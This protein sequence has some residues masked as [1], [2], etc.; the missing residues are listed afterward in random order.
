MD[1]KQLRYFVTVVKMRSFSAAGKS[2]FISQSTLSKSMQNLE[3]E[4]GV[5]LIYFNA[6]KL[7]TTSY[8]T[9][10]YNLAQN[11]LSQYE[12]IS[13]SL[14]GMAALEKGSL[15]IGIP[16][17]IGTCVF[18]RL[19]TGFIQ[20]YP[21]IDLI[22]TQDKA[23]VIQ[24]M[25][26]SNRLDFGFTMLPVTNEFLSIPLIRER[27]VCVV[28]KS[29]PLAEK[30]LIHFSDLKNEKLILLDEKFRMYTNVLTYCRRE[31]FE[32]HIIMQLQEWDLILQLVKYNVG[33]TILPKPI[34]ELYPDEDLVSV[35]LNV[36]TADFSIAMISPKNQYETN[37]MRVFKEHI[38]AAAALQNPALFPEEEEN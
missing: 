18:P 31:N 17:I 2:L 9:E 14:H 5:P 16:P 26:A 32:P 15:R 8:G 38:Q 34:V 7:H 28:H 25:V 11:L 21:G 30:E 29:N 12:A 19:I 22:I 35:P 13:N 1:I 20:K 4:L 37:V 23:K 36:E 10:L 33:S 3:E 27:D 24:Q 6:K